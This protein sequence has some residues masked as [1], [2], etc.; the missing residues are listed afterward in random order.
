MSFRA[1]CSVR[2]TPGQLRTAQGRG[3][4]AWRRGES[5]GT[6]M[7]R[8]V[9][10]AVGG[11]AAFALALAVPAWPVTAAALDCNAVDAGTIALD[12]PVAVDP[13]REQRFVLDLAAPAD[14]A[15]MLEPRVPGAEVAICDPAGFP[16]GRP[17]EPAATA[18]SAADAHAVGEAV[19]AV[20]APAAARLT[21]RAP[22][23]PA[24]AREAP[25]IPFGTP[26]SA[27][28]IKDYPRT[29]SFTGSAGQ[30]VRIAARSD[31]DT[32]LK[33]V[34]PTAAGGTGQ[35][36][37]DDD[38][39]GLNPEIRRRLL[40]T[41]TY[42]VT[43]E[44]LS[45]DPEDVMIELREDA[46]PALAAAVVQA[47]GTVRPGAPVNAS[48]GEGAGRQLWRLPVR[49]GRSYRVTLSA[50]FDAGLDLGLADPLEPADGSPPLGIA[51][52]RS[53]D[54]DGSGEEMLA[55][56]AAADGEVLL[57]VRALDTAGTGGAYALEV[58][59]PQG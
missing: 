37:D 53:S 32:R 51:L 59:E 25:A 30:A 19:I 10:G 31:G 33:L 34:G 35:L 29:W 17:L 57:Q 8:M 2:T 4:V 45:D 14:I 36:A 15:V 12:R 1:P 26:V 23:T 41:G 49:A 44:T 11:R 7:G 6:G 47:A 43:V 21:V 13:G 18:G 22:G 48:L 42:F 39:E 9:L 54:T 55:F 46:A 20:L 16:F 56:T 50:R 27:H 58:S 40:R 38:S 28:L 3:A 5:T 24:S 52:R